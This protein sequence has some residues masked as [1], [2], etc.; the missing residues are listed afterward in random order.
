VISQYYILDKSIFLCSW[1][2]M[3]WIVIWYVWLILLIF[4]RELQLVLPLC[5]FLSESHE[6][7]PSHNPTIPLCSALLS[8]SSTHASLLLHPQTGWTCTRRETAG[9]RHDGKRLTAVCVCVCV[10]ECVCVCV[11]ECVC[12][13]VCVSVCAMPASSRDTSALFPMMQQ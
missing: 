2:E 11:C 8:F 12:V 5:V 4:I 9:L 10:C 7:S 13:C 1:S 3:S 6:F